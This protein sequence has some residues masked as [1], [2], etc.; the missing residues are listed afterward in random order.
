MIY[1]AENKINGKRYVGYTHNFENRKRAHL[2]KSR[3]GAETHFHRAIRKYGKNNFDWKIIDE[4]AD[5]DK[6]SYYIEKYDTFRNGYN[7]TKGGGGG[8]TISMKSAEEKKRQG[9]KIGNIPWNKGVSMKELGYDFYNDRKPRS[10]TDE[11][12]RNHSDLV[13][14]EKYYEGLKNR[15][16]GRQ[17]K[18]KR[19]SDGKI[20]NS[21]KECREELKITGYMF[22]KNI[23]ELYEV[24]LWNNG[25][26]CKEW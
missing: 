6:E 25:N 24:I 17:Y 18:V 12:K 23:G 20:W 14:S 15:K 10:F 7:M 4:S 9:A 8:D 2:K 13:K 21:Q 16:T 11:Q 1:I 22:R 19:I 5:I 3:L 26:Y